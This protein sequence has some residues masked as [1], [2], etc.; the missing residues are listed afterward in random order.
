VLITPHTGGETR[1][2]EDRVTGI[3]VENLERLWAG[4]DDLV[5]RIV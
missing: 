1:K 4:R 2:Y 5:N 3:V